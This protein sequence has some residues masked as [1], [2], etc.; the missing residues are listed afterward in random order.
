MSPVTQTAEVAVK[1]ASTREM[2]CRVAT[3]NFRRT[4]PAPMMPVKPKRSIWDGLNRL[5][6]IAY[7]LTY[8]LGRLK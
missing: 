5:L 2:P 1:R 8:A 6:N 7:G 3:G 4:V